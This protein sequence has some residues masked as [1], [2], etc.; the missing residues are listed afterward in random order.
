MKYIKKFNEE[1]DNKTYLSAADKLSYNHPNRAKKLRDH[2]DYK[3][4][5]VIDYSIYNIL[6]YGDIVGTAK[7][8]LKISDSGLETR[9]KIPYLEVIEQDL[10]YSKKIPRESSAKRIENIRT[11]GGWFE[12]TIKAIYRY[13]QYRIWS[14][15]VLSKIRIIL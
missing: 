12:N 8:R 9:G 2:V 5:P 14:I 4:Q 6:F 13:N 7:A 11:G 15:R 3:E 10:N 1:L